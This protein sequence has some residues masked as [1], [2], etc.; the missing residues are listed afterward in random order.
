MRHRDEDNYLLLAEAP[1]LLPPPL[2]RLIADLSHRRLQ[3][4]CRHT[5][6]AA[7]LVPHPRNPT[8]HR[9]ASSLTAQLNSYGIRI[10]AGRA[11]ALMNA[12]LGAPVDELATKLGIHRATAA[13]WKR[14]A[15]RD[16]NNPVPPPTHSRVTA[17]SYQPPPL[18]A[19]PAD[20]GVASTVENAQCAARTRAGQRA[21]R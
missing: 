13:Q 8:Q 16:R 1:V 7:W 21:G 4:A 12:A 3:D 2:A 15:N 18:S 19:P 5:S 11:A 9:L 6:G 20:P 17:V 10:K 14:R